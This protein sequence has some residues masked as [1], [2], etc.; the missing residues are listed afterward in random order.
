MAKELFPS[1]FECDCGHE[2]HFF[3]NTVREMKKMSE[4]KR[5][6]LRDSDSKEEHT[7]VFYKGNAIEVI[8]P[9]LGKCKI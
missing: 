1:S 3:E 7:I 6:L 5:V 8:C 9:K 2:S 4:K